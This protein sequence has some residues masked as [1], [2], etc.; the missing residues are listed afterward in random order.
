[1]EAK[2]LTVIGLI[3]TALPTKPDT[4]ANSVDPDELSVLIFV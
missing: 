4:S 3:L 2:L 1:M